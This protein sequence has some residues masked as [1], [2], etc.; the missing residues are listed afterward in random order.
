[1]QKSAH[2]WLLWMAMIFLI[3]CSAEA[4]QPFPP[5][6]RLLTQ[7]R[8]GLD[9]VN[10]LELDTEF[11][12]FTYLNFFNGGGLAAGDFNQDGWVDLYFTSNQNENQLF[13]NQGNFQFTNATEEA[14]MH[15]QA[16]WTTGT[17]VVDIN[18]DGL[19]DIF[20][21]QLGNFPPMEG[22]NQLYVC[23]EIKD[24]IPVYV[25]MAEA[26]GLAFS[27][28]SQQA[29][30]LDYDL[31]GDLDMF[32]LNHSVHQSG[33]SRGRYRVPEKD[34]RSGDRLLRNDSENGQIQF[35]DVTMESGILS[36]AL[37][38]GL[39]VVVG[40]VNLDGWPDLYITNDFQENDYLYIN[41]Q[42]G[43]FRESVQAQ[44]MHTSRF[45]MGVDMADINNDG[46]SEIYSLDMLPED[47]FI[48]KTSLGEDGF[49]VYQLKL[50]HGFHYQYTRN[51]LQL[52]NGNGSFSEI[53][54]FAGVHATDWSW[55]PLFLDMN[56]DG[57]KDLFVSNGIPRRMNDIDYVNFK[58]GGSYD[59]GPGG[60][61][62]TSEAS[63]RETIERMP[64]VKLSNK[65][66]LNQGDLTF[67]DIEQS[68]L[69]ARTSYSNG[70]VYADLD[71][72]GDLDIVTNNIDDSPYL[73]ENLTDT[74]NDST[75][76]F[77][78]LSFHGPPSNVLGIG[79]KV[80][81]KKAEEQLVYEHYLT[82]GYLSSVAP[83]LHIGLGDISTIEQILLIWP[84]QT[85]EVL[86]NLAFNQH[87]EVKWKSGLPAVAVEDQNSEAE[88]M[89]SL[90]EITEDIGIQYA[91]K[92]N[93]FIEFNR[94]SLMP[95]MV[96]SEGPALAVGDINGD[97]REDVFIGSAR[98]GTAGLFF[99]EGD[100]SFRR[101]EQALFAE[102]AEFEE[103]DA[104]LI[105]IDNDEDLDL[106]LAAGGNEFFGNKEG[107]QQRVY[108]ND[109]QG[110]FERQDLFPEA[111]MTASC[112]LPADFNG[113][114]FM[115]VFIGARAI[116]AAY[117]LAPTS[118]LYQNRGDGRF[119]LVTP[120]LAPELEEIGL[121]Q[122]GAWA[123]M[124]GDGDQDLLL[125][126]EWDQI[127]LFRNQGDRF[128]KSSISD[129]KGWWK[130]VLPYDYD[131]DGDMDLLAGNLGKNTRLKASLEQPLRMYIKD[132]DFNG[133]ADQILTYYLE[134]RE[135]LFHTHDELLKQLPALKKKYLYASDMATATVQEI[136]GRQNLST[137]E[138]LEA[139]YLA[140]AYFEQTAEG[141]F[142]LHPLPDPLQFSTLEAA[143]LVD[144]NEDGKKEVLLGGNFYDCNVEMGRYDAD[145]G[146]ILSIG[147]QGEMTVFSLH[148]SPIR[149]QIRKIESVQT[150]QGRY[151]LWAR[152][153]DRM[154][155]LGQ[156]E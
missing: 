90:R 122:D 27:G 70:A 152:N 119:T 3:S 145:F 130:F 64:Q 136:F 8:T 79:T 39:G 129:H 144:V 34:E 86:D 22:S 78:H 149:G 154:L 108:L 52:N 134:G 75:K 30:F 21:A 106:L 85:A 15:G 62:S 11:N 45:S 51:N 44:M 92:E 135:Y 32:Q 113:D 66:F 82:R 98:G 10:R 143:H 58:L 139:N 4:E 54:L 31:D 53:G 88:Q 107:R 18:N 126:M 102:D 63:F 147:Q 48:L 138:I 132:Y 124:D 13:L 37:G 28:L 131:Q 109:G 141:A 156:E 43:T 35:T 105:D 20:V 93:S 128:E 114:G 97:G 42:D 74:N 80:I 19:L 121:V 96:S 155:V 60:N 95:H 127:M 99:Q 76:A 104:A 118:C 115:D 9:V 91:H 25:D 137:A 123:D 2:V 29:A 59:E 81:V 94:E 46:W 72:D 116:P 146:H 49:D 57:D 7:E 84:D 36:T 73:Y 112:I 12:V 110:M 150:S 23:Q 26:Y 17:C 16:G 47:P 117:G 5:Q 50:R 65:F 100:G 101:S 61:P 41:Q 6:F 103:V 111:N 68:I 77:L 71:N 40:D 83:G 125:A 151:Y 153:G 67:A 56:H 142:V 120:A 133:Q 38:F 69:D 1:M 148:N 87:H 33:I 55:A 14:R 24:G 140:S 89:T